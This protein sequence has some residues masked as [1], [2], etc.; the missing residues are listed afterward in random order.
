MSYLE[1]IIPYLSESEE[2]EEEKE[3]VS[4][5]SQAGSSEAH[6]APLGEKGANAPTWTPADVAGERG[7]AIAC[8]DCSDML[9]IE[10]GSM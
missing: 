3:R 4:A 1:R 8:L 10:V 7:R 9:A 5:V 2:E 6:P